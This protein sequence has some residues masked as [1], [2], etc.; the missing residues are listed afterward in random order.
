LSAIFTIADLLIKSVQKSKYKILS[1]ANYDYS[2]LLFSA[3]IRLRKNTREEVLAQNR[4]IERI[5]NLGILLKQA[6]K[7]SDWL[8]N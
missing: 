4:S 3:L 8:N 6:A 5:K 2:L 7:L 1:G